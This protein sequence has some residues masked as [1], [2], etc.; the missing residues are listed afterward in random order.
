MN[1][2]FN[3]GNLPSGHLQQVLK[4]TIFSRS[5][6]VTKVSVWILQAN[7]K[8]VYIP[9]AFVHYIV[10]L[11]FVDVFYMN[12]LFLS[13]FFSSV[14]SPYMWVIAPAK[15]WCWIETFGTLAERRIHVGLAA[16]LR[17]MCLLYTVL[18]SLI[19]L[20]SCFVFFLEFTFSQSG[21]RKHWF[22]FA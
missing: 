16:M 20:C 9:F 21:F 12:S 22:V 2:I 6:N 1:I 18:F 10:C 4:F 11:M 3:S 13:V 17:Y 14:S 15:P 5:L 7:V 19:S 8:S